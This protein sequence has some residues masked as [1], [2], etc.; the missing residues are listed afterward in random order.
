MIRSTFYLYSL[1]LPPKMTQFT[2]KSNYFIE[3]SRQVRVRTN[4][5]NAHGNVWEV[6][7]PG[8]QVPDQVTTGSQS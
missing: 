2:G 1:E 3:P 6:S 8:Q 4:N 5:E 7:Y